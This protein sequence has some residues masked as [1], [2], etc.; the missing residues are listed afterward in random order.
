MLPVS[1]HPEGKEIIAV[2]ACNMIKTG[3]LAFSVTAET[4]HFATHKQFDW[5]ASEFALR[6]ILSTHTEAGQVAG[7]TSIPHTVYISLLHFQLVGPWC[8]RTDH[9]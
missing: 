5:R 2:A 1:T 6:A 7:R 8:N 4:F 3:L 9:T